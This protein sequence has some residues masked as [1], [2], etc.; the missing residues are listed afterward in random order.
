MIVV[1]D[2]EREALDRNGFAVLPGIVSDA[3]CKRLIK[4]AAEIV[5]HFDAEAHRGIFSTTDQSRTMDDYFVASANEVGC[6]FEEEAFDEEGVLRQAKALSINKI[7]HALHRLDPV[8]SAFSSELALTEAGRALGLAEPVALQSMYIY[9]QPRIGGEVN[10]H[11]DA[12]FLYTDP[13]SVIGFWFALEDATLENGCLWALPGA[14]RLGLE[15]RYARV[16]GG[17]AFEPLQAMSWPQENAIP[18]EVPAGS[19]VLLHGLLPHRSSANRSDRSR[20]AYAVHLIDGAANYPADNW[21][22]L[23]NPGSE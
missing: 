4:R 15:K 13:V 11:Q 12:T 20:Q 23:P 9:K 18:I 3:W 16:G 7:G 5:A 21:L 10:L 1:A 2:A 6:F 19:L 17:F 8:F 22:Q 14:H